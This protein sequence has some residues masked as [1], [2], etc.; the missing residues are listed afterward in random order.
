MLFKNAL[1]ASLQRQS[2]RNMGAGATKGSKDFWKQST[3][4]GVQKNSKNISKNPNFQVL[5]II[6]DNFS[7]SLAVVGC[8]IFVYRREQQHA[9]HYHRPEWKEYPW[10]SIRNKNYAWGDGKHSLFHT[11]SVNGIVGKG[12][13]APAHGSGSD[14]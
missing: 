12:Y 8:A 2:V 9:A 11:A 5:S 10:L 13:E 4:I 3:Y 14:H 7:A 6:F 1:Q